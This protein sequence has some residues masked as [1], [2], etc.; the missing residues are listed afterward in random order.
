MALNKPVNPNQASAALA[1]AV[2]AEQMRLL[3]ENHADRYLTLLI[4]G[5][6]IAVV[7]PV[8]PAWLLAGWFGLSL[9]AVLVRSWLGFRFRAAA[10]GAAATRRWMVVFSSGAAFTGILWGCVGSIALVTP[11]PA[12]QFFSVMIAGGMLAG[13]VMIDAPSFPVMISFAVPAVVP[14]ILVLFTRGDLMHAGMAL[15]LTLFSTI[16]LAAALKLNRVIVLNIEMRFGR[17]GLLAKVQTSEAAMAEAQRLA[18]VGSFDIDLAT[19]I[20]A[21]SPEGYSVCGFSPADDPIPFTTLLARIHREDIAAVEAH[22]ARS[23]LASAT[24]GID[25]RL[26][27]PDGAIKFLRTTPN[28]VFDTA[29]RPARIVGAIQDITDQRLADDRL[30]FANLVLKTQMDVSPDGVMVVDSNRHLISV[31]RR[32]GEIWR[33]SAAELA[34]QDDDGLRDRIAHQAKTPLAHLARVKYLAEHPDAVGFDEIELADGRLLEQHTRPL[35]GAEGQYLGRVWLYS[36]ITAQRAAEQKLQFAN[37]LLTTQMEASPDGVMVVDTKSHATSF[38]RRFSEIWRIPAEVLASG[39]DDAIRGRLRAQVKNL[40][41]YLARVEYLI[42]HPDEVGDDEIETL[43]GRVIERHSTALRTEAGVDLGRV[44]FY[45]D[46]TERKQAAATLDYRDRLLHAVTAATSIAVAAVSLAEGV[47]EALR[48]IGESMAVHRIL[49]MQDMPS[50]DPP[51]ATRFQWEIPG[52][53]VPFSLT[54]ANVHPFDYTEMAAWRRP[55]REGKMVF[56][57]TATGGVRAML[58]AFEI[59]SCILVPVYAAGGVWG[60]ICVDD[61]LAARNWTASEMETLRI[62]ADT[63]G[64]LIVRERARVALETSEERFRLLTTTAKDAVILAG[65][66]GEVLQ[67]NPAAE[68]IFGYTAAEALGRQS[69][70]LIVRPAD[71]FMVGREVA[72]ASAALGMTLEFTFM[73]KDGSDIA[74]EISISAIPIAGRQGILSILRDITERRQEEAKLQFANIM[75]KTQMEASPDGILAIGADRQVLSYNQRFVDM[76]DIPPPVLLAES[77]DAIRMVLARAVKNTPGFLARVQEVIEHP[78]A[79]FDDELATLD[80][81]IIE[82]HTRAMHAPGGQ[83]LGRVWFFRDITAR[84]KAEAL[85]L[86]LARYDVLTGLANRAVFVEAVEHAI[87]RARRGGP[88]FAVLY[89]DLDNFKNVNDTLG[90]PAGDALLREVADR[91]RANSRDTDTVAR[92]GG[93]EFAMVASDVKDASDAASL[94]EKLIHAI[95]APLSL[96]G[97]EVHPAVSIGVD[98]SSSGTNDVETLLSHADVALYRA[99]AEGRG[100]FR[101]FTEAMERNIRARVSL[102]YELREAIGR[103]ELFL[104]YQP[105]VKAGTGR[106]TGFEALVRWRHPTRG[107]LMPGYFVPVAEATG[108]IGLLGHFVLWQACRQAKAWLDAGLPMPRMAVNISPTQFKTPAVLE[109]DI[110]AALAATGLAPR[111]LELELTESVLMDTS[112]AHN[113]ILRRLRELGVK[114]ALDDFG[115]GYSSLDYLRR[116]P[117]DRLKIAGSFTK[118]IESGT[119]DASI[120]RAIIALAQEL[121]IEVIVE[122]V[123]TKSQL[124]LLERWDCG[125]VQ[126]YYFARPMEA[127]AAEALL[128]NGGI[129]QPARAMT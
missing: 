17:D 100:I 77:A 67:W 58:D 113:D 114:L 50:E 94:A 8:Y 18:R 86:S 65:P 46:V 39:D 83:N 9:C 93:D 5:I 27:M 108:I 129:I 13:G 68:R 34:G 103:N 63:A 10:H 99:K 45:R 31:N 82:R 92:F 37:V 112:Q 32:F 20:I 88:G 102:G 66:D 21:L 123:E 59:K 111:L 43:D 70:E 96:Q 128:R 42:G 74:T 119:G 87:A 72:K 85:A 35:L 33:L 115:T 12:L 56:A 110:T 2:R 125:E 54:G 84:R 23:S 26:V 25:Y 71:R 73:R 53:A 6:V 81:R 76:W 97:N 105:Q 120:V 16:I 98:L 57:D 29:G 11:S 80:G 117:V 91:L 48:K 52:I 24:T 118:H 127:N 64:A 126:G 95:N 89:L 101:F 75:L 60:F 106:I 14:A 62:L 28:T 90:H 47:P 104:L 1:Q 22:V 61:C 38:S 55:L 51:L 124:E 109:A 121:K 79:V 116:F 36:D 122:G 40:D 69:V 4:A 30:Q 7:R 49:V 3:V 19:G 107:I 41:T 44:R 78:D 15:L